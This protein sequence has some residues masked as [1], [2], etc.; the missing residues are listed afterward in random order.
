MEEKNIQELKEFRDLLNG[1]QYSILREKAAGMNESDIAEILD[2]ME[3]EDMLKMFRIFPKEL[4]T[5]VFSQMEPDSQQY[6]I[7]SL[8]EK[9]AGVVIDNLYSDD[10]ADLLEEMPAN[11][12][13]KILANARPDTRQDI[14]HLL[15]YKDD[16][17]GSVM[18]VEFVDLKENMTVGQAL[19]RIRSLKMDCETA[20]CCYVLDSKRILL[21]AVSLRHLV[22]SNPED[23]ISDLMDRDVISCSTSE[24]EEKVANQFKKYDLTAMP[25]VDTELRLVGIITV[26]DVM[27]IMEKETT[28]DMEKMAAIIP[29]DR[30]YLK[31]SVFETWKKRFPWLLL[32]MISATFTGRIITTYENALSAY[33]VLT[34]YIPMLMDTG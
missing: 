5:D 20:D 19:D 7:N 18:T 34:A 4:A 15:R 33:V 25:V 2:S 23:N 9:E 12:V 17:A 6:I 11:V 16:S 10:A 8:S 21:G 13:R 32:L 27:D 24:D 29:G 28:E 26:D 14:N 31:T 22:F 3:D 30:A 1:R